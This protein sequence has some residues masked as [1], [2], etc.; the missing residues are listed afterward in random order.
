MKFNLLFILIA[1]CFLLVPDNL[2]G[3]GRGIKPQ[4]WNNATIAW[5]ANENLFIDHTISYNVLVDKELP[6]SEFSFN[7]TVAYRF[8][9]LIFAHGGLYIAATKQSKSI[10]SLNLDRIWVFVCHLNCKKEEL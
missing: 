1:V 9:D 7:N 6:W 3:Q 4:Y 8:N 2:K 5:G 10:N